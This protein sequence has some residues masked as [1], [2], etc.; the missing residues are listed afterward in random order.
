MVFAATLWKLAE[1]CE[2]NNV[3]NDTIRDRL[4]CGLRSDV[5]QK[6]LRTQSALTLEKAV[7]ISVSME[8]A[9]KESYHQLNSRAKLHKVSKDEKGT[10][11]KC[12]RCDKTLQP[13]VGVRTL[14]A[15]NVGE[16]GHIELAGKSK[17]RDK[18]PKH[19]HQKP[20][21]SFIKRLLVHNIHQSHPTT[22]SSSDEAV[23]LSVTGGARGYW[24]SPLL[25]GLPVWMEINTS[26][27][28]TI[29]SETVYKKVFAESC[30]SIIQSH[31]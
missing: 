16:K 18:Q 9:A 3:L 31:S 10:Q 5:A 11:S 13:S 12:Y 4:V 6:R 21:H 24:V 27:A 1:H 14:I 19:S 30:L 20:K 17:G 2:F 15:G 29:V 8:L 25:D 7:E 26:S 22:S 23:V 28:V